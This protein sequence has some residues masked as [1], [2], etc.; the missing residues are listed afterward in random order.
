MSLPIELAPYAPPSS[1][2]TEPLA[3]AKVP[4]VLPPPLPDSLTVAAFC[5]RYD[6]GG[7][8][9]TRL[10]PIDV[11]RLT[12]IGLAPPALEALAGSD[13]QIHDPAA[14]QRLFLALDRVDH[15]GNSRSIAT[16][17]ASPVLDTLDHLW[18]ERERAPGDA[19]MAGARRV[20]WWHEDI[21]LSVRG[22]RQGYRE[23]KAASC[24]MI[25]GYDRSLSTSLEAGSADAHYMAKY[26]DS[27]GR[28]SGY[29]ADFEAGLTAVDHWLAEGRPVLV[30]LSWKKP[31]D[32]VYNTDRITDHFV[33]ITGRFADENGLVYY[34]FADP[35]DASTDNRFYV[36]DASGMLFR[37]GVAGAPSTAT[38]QYQV[39]QVRGYR[40]GDFDDFTWT[41]KAR[42]P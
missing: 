37:P 19:T 20:P 39:S 31:K 28:I 13:R 36:D 9:L 7:F 14:L 27:V 22:V 2:A 1:P 8:D 40:D 29:R 18:R 42:T 32:G 30:G 21:D 12:R 16:A 35:A 15:D 17:D 23:C 3:L 10:R 5:D 38:A 4:A 26:E 41:P 24:R 6:R 11:E 33:V 25:S 34:R